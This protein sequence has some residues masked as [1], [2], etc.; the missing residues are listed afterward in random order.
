MTHLATIQQ[1]PVR[2]P[3]DEGHPVTTIATSPG[4]AH[5]GGDVHLGEFAVYF[6]GQLD[7]AI[8]NEGAAGGPGVRTFFV[9][10][11]VIQPEQRAPVARLDDRARVS[12][13]LWEHSGGGEG[14][15]GE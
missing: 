14:G 13:V 11:G 10:F 5:H 7:L 12:I 8:P 6:P 4:V 3:A 1:P 9:V 15:G 2:S